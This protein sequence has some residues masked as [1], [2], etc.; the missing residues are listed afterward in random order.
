V[1]ACHHVFHVADEPVPVVP[2]EQMLVGV[3]GV[4]EDGEAIRRVR[5]IE[6]VD[7]VAERLRPTRATQN[8]RLQRVDFFFR[9][10]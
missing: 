1:I 4:R 10:G 5:R 3:S 2:A 6:I 9:F 7:A 8:N